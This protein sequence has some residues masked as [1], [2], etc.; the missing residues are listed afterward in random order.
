MMKA[1]LEFDFNDAEDRENYRMTSKAANLCNA[2]FEIMGYLRH[3][4]KYSEEQTF[5][6]DEIEDAFVDICEKHDVVELL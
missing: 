2:L 5:D 1:I 4:R 6:I 3:K